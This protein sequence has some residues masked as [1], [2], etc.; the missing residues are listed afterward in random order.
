[1]NTGMRKR[2]DEVESALGGGNQII[3]VTQYLDES[4]E[5]AQAKVDRWRNG[6][7]EDEVWAMPSSK[8]LVIRIRKFCRRTSD[9]ELP[10]GH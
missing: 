6:E 1:M 8:D 10:S 4:E 2:L 7:L 3:C 9:S 5:D